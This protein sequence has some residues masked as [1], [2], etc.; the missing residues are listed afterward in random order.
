MLKTY[1]AFFSR[2]V[3][4]LSCFLSFKHSCNLLACAWRSYL[5]TCSLSDF[6][7]E[8]FLVSLQFVCFLSLYFDCPHPFSW[9]AC[10]LTSLLYCFLSCYLHTLFVKFL[11]TVSLAFPFLL[12]L[13]QPSIQFL[14]LLSCSLIC[15]YFHG[16][17]ASL[18]CTLLQLVA[19]FVV[20]VV[21]SAAWFVAWFV[22]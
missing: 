9:L 7:L 1:L 21:T 16:C 12:P 22:V 2:T 14:C 4:L 13:F 20:C 18:I 10:F 11:D 17:F 15:T 6:L 5:L 3:W 8:W 19:C